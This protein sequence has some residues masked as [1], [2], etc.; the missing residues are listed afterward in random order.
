VMNPLHLISR[1]VVVLLTVFL[2]AAP[3]AA[4]Q[5]A[6]ST[7]PEGIAAGDVTQTSVILWAHSTALGALTLE[8]A[9][10]PAFSTLLSTQTLTVTDPALPVKT[11]FTDLTPGTAYVYRVRDAAGT[12]AE[13]RFRTPAAPGTRV[14]L[15]FGVTGD[16]RGELSPYPSIANV[17]V[18]ELDFFVQHGDT[19][20]A[21]FPS[22]ALG[23]MA[24]TVEDFHLKY[25]ESLGARYG[26]NT[27]AALRASTAIFSMIDDHEVRNDF[28][29][30][31]PIAS[32]PRFSGDGQTL[33]NDSALFEAGLQVF[34]A[35]NPLADETYGETGDPRTASERK[36][37]RYRT[38][39]DTAAIFLL[40]AR[41]F[42]DAA[43]PL[44]L[45]GGFSADALKAYIQKLYTPGRTMLGAAQ[46]DL[47]KA[48]LLTAQAAGVLW[49]F[50][51]VPEPVQ[52]LGPLNAADRYE[53]YAA[54]RADLLRFIVQNHLTNVVFVAADI[55]GT[56]VNNLTYADSPDAPQQPTGTWEISTESAAFDAP[57]GPT[58]TSIAVRLGLVT[59]E[60]KQ[61][62]DSLPAGFK[63]VSLLP[64]LNAQI[65]A[66]N[67]DMMGLEDSDVDATLQ[68]GLWIATQT[69]GWTEFEIDATGLL[70]VTTYGIPAYTQ[71]EMTADPAGVSSRVPGIV[72][73]FSVQPR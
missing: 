51:L 52:N 38:W 60:Q 17:P 59:T 57:F 27:W 63:D 8:I 23:Q 48:D 69:F 64:I 54:E 35:Y 33:I 2:C 61:V 29:G 28:A 31:A 66:F 73:Q 20:Y 55:H 62:Y 19:V 65:T 37:Y 71:A 42:R 16:W 12:Q 72:Q 45:G 32:D 7:L 46:L 1:L 4:R 22:P 11:L 34:Q 3:A 67:Y 39:G 30:G 43:I 44:D 10:D 53:G 50:I 68:R 70:Q 49:K 47:L 41:S 5:M 15:R 9:T 36:L 21:D 56:L 18:R 25:A 14:P 13:G 58:V 26:L 40:D 6:D 24:F